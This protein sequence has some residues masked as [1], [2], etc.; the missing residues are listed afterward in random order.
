MMTLNL[1]LLKTLRDRILDS[2]A[3][4]GHF[5]DNCEAEEMVGQTII[6]A[7]KHVEEYAKEYGGPFSFKGR[8]DPGDNGAAYRR[9]IDDGM[10]VES[11]L[12]RTTFGELPTGIEPNAAG[13]V[14]VIFPTPMLL[15][16]L[17]THFRIVLDSC[18]TTG[19]P[20]HSLT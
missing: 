1:D 8:I 19:A 2:S 6:A 15:Q 12:H 14:T 11:F 5:Y 20:N 4:L 18:I 9:L 16:K 13:Y 10:F 7:C 3:S 17:A